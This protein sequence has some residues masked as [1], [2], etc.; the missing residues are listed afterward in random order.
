MR[1][2]TLIADMI[3]RRSAGIDIDIRVIKTK[4]DIMQDVSLVKIG[5][6]GVFVKE[7]EDALLN[8]EVDM[9]V[10]SMKDVPSELPEGLTIAVTPPRDDPRDVLISRN[11][12]KIE[13]MPQGARIGTGS[14]RRGMQLRKLLPDVE[15]VPIRGNLDTRIK[16]IETE[17][18]AGVIVA[19][20]G[21]KRMG[22]QQKVSQ[23]IPVEV[24]LPPVGQGVLAIEL[25][26]D[27]RASHDIVSF[28]NDI[29][30]WLEVHAERAFL[31]RMGGGCQLPMAAYAKKEGPMLTIRGLLGSLDGHTLIT[32]EIRGPVED[33]KMI[34]TRLAESILQRGG[35]AIIDEFYST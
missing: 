19:A 35:Q 9:A 29:K 2:T 6:K 14:L 31:R 32:E 17:N 5:G 34:G 25:R 30:T 1:Q 4:G 22:W 12:I 24:M 28:L 16:K 7:I 11:L 15:I 20:A 23:F 13:K 8:N 33:F 10:H 21:I 26:S 3:R 18:L 27:D